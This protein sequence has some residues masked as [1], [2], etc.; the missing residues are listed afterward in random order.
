[1][2]A[3]GS[4]SLATTAFQDG[5]RTCAGFTAKRDDA[6]STS[7]G[8]F[9]NR[10]PPGRIRGRA[11]VVRS[12]YL[13]SCAREQHEAHRRGG[14]AAYAR[15]NAMIFE[16][17]DADFDGQLSCDEFMA[18]VEAKMPRG[19][20]RPWP[21]RKLREWFHELDTNDNG[22]LTMTE[23][24]LFALREA[25][26]H[27]GAHL[28]SMLARYD[29]DG[30]HSLDARELRT[31]AAELG[32]GTVAD[33]LLEKLDED[34]SGT[35]QYAEVIRALSTGA[36]HCR[37]VAMA[38]DHHHHEHRVGEDLL[39]TWA[40]S[41]PVF[42]APPPAEA[43]DAPSAS[44]RRASG[45]SRRM[46]EI[47]EH[48][49]QGHGEEA[50]LLLPM[51]R[52]WLRADEQR[53]LA[54][55][56]L[57][58]RNGSGYV[59]AREFGEAIGTLGFHLPRSA[60]EALFDELALREHGSR[61]GVVAHADEHYHI[62]FHALNEWLNQ[63]R[64]AAA[65]ADRR[66]AAA[67]AAAPARPRAGARPRTAATSREMSQRAPPVPASFARASARMGLAAGRIPGAG[68]GGWE[69]VRAAGLGLGLPRVGK[70]AVVKVGA[71]L[72]PSKEAS[73]RTLE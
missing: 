34:G 47:G 30:D 3:W 17:A 65:S 50:G 21:E 45:P 51:V 11:G 44:T 73:P 10:H 59:S 61:R 39:T 41:K 71:R 31:F 53:A 69:R 72:P 15:D 4:T 25:V 7:F 14:T 35:I 64:F 22:S 20:G 29:Q 24:F 67:V 40:S 49:E 56:R 63:E 19:D 62:G 36:E 16:A 28:S 32:F 12:K 13:A 18:M 58:D 55:F 43:A 38:E 8:F 33:E 26:L 23:F 1:M 57:A 42:G 68:R 37:K 60:C 54:I 27:E 9:H 70:P 5:L 46:E 48:I 66:A 52:D 2:S 6:L